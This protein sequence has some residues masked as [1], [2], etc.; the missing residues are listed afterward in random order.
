MNTR[1][2][3][4]TPV[5]AAAN[6]AYARAREFA[7]RVPVEVLVG[8]AF[9]G[10]SVLVAGPLLGRGWLLLLD[11][12]SGPAHFDVTFWPQAGSGD[13]GNGLPLE[14]LRLVLAHAVGASAAD[15]LFLLL[16]IAVGGPGMFR[17]AR[18]LGAG[19]LPAL[20]AGVVATINPFTLDRMLAGHLFLLLATA[21]LP[22]ALVPVLDALEGRGSRRGTLAIGVWLAALAAIDV[23]VA[24]MYAGLVV[25]AALLARGGARERLELVAVS[26]GCALVLSSY[27]IVPNLLHA[28]PSR[29][30]VADLTSYATRPTGWRVL[31]TLLALYGF[32]RDEFARPAAQHPLLYALVVPLVALAL[33][34]AVVVARSGRRQLALFLGT[35][36]VLALLL[37]AGTAFPPTADAFRF[38]YQ[39][40]GWFRIYREPEKFVGVLVLV[41]ALLGAFALE[42][43][44]RLARAPGTVAALLAIALALGYGYGLFWGLGG[45]VALGEYPPSWTIAARVMDRLGPG[46]VLVFPWRTYAAW[47]FT[48][49]HVVGNPAPSFFARKVVASRGSGLP[50][51]RDEA[52]DPA[53][54][55]VT[56][57]L[58]DRGRVHD[59]GRRVA[60]LGVRYVLVLREADAASYNFV[61]RQRDL[62]LVYR[63]RRLT[64]YL[65]TASHPRLDSSGTPALNGT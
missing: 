52:G 31:P 12:P 23:H 59:L 35:S 10:L 21:L 57:A 13:L 58:H 56:S 46:G 50:G 34:G 49:G 15:K 32:W 5:P 40:V 38:V 53:A 27:W 60:P 22:W 11:F 1:T 25:L 62:R 64:L 17:L 3:P 4:L 24:G 16:P 33:V 14:L 30:G 26:I 65:S 63:T 19:S 45:R 37:A 2:R 61:R 36:G 28:G 8:L 7:A 9:L 6:G 29:A 20:Y 54:A 47:S 39:H 51:S 43:L 55:V 48:G 18:R 44:R 41:Y 42:R